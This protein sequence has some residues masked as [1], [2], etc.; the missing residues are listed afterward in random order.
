MVESEEKFRRRL[1]GG[2][3]SFPPED[4]G[5]VWGYYKCLAAVG[6]IDP[7][8]IDITPEDLEDAKD[9][10]G[11]WDPDGFHLEKAKKAFDK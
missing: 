7:Q 6:K 5:G 1:V 10:V 3:H 4:C 11:D 8:S 2:E 9:W